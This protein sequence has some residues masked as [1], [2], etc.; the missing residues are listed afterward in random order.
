MMAFRAVLLS[1]LCVTLFCSSVRG[2]TALDITLSTSSAPENSRTAEQPESP[3]TE[4]HANISAATNTPAGAHM[5]VSTRLDSSSTAGD[6]TDGST[7]ADTTT[8]ITPGGTGGQPR[9]A[10]E[11]EVSTR[12]T[13]PT[14][15]GPQG[16]RPSMTKAIVVILVVLVILL[17]LLLYV[18]SVLRNL[19][20]VICVRGAL[21]RAAAGARAVLSWLG[22]RLWPRKSGGDAGR[23]EEEDEEEGG[24]EPDVELGNGMEAE[25]TKDKKEE[26]EEEEDSSD[27]YS[28]TEGFDLRERARQREGGEEE[29]EET[30]L[31]QNQRKD[32]EEEA[33]LLEKS[34]KEGVEEC[35]LTV[36]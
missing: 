2:L 8:L 27:D 26:E 28:S 11:A 12:R 17:I 4:P 10:T 32:Q 35:D 33:T 7:P 1:A 23:D 22:I 16:E 13:G 30:S 9:E 15:P 31:S 21:G 34:K 18:L 25:D 5:D 24:S 29:E 14:L 19:R 36:L 3:T 20:L 6:I